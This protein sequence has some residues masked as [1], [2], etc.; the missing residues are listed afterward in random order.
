MK[1]FYGVLKGRGKKNRE[2]HSLYAS[3]IMILINGHSCDLERCASSYSKVGMKLPLS[4]DTSKQDKFTPLNL[5]C[6]YISC[7]LLQNTEIRNI[8]DAS[9]VKPNR[10]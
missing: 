8:Y 6:K 3:K 10:Y 9:Q 2:S 4:C 5:L 1:D 7:Y